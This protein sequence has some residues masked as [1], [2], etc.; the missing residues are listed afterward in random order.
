MTLAP[1]TPS[2]G[3]PSAPATRTRARCHS[4]G[5]YAMGS[6]VTFWSA[7]AAGTPVASS[8]PLTSSACQVERT[9]TR[10][11]RGSTVASSASAG[12]RLSVAGV[13]CTGSWVATT[14]ALWLVTTIATFESGSSASRGG[15]AQSRPEG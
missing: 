7:A 9:S 15:C 1:A 10:E 8:S 6:G 12:G 3:S 14:E 2:G 5:S 4:D 13:L 11:R